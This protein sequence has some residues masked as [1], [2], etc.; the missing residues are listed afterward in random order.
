[1]EIENIHLRDYLRVLRKR[2]MTIFTFF[3]ITITIVTIVTFTMTPSYRAST[4]LLIEKN[5]TNPLDNSSYVRF[6]PEFLETQ[7]QI[8]KG[9]NVARSVV[10]ILSLDIVYLHHF[11]PEDEEKN[12]ITGFAETI[13]ELIAG[14]L[15][16]SELEQELAVNGSEFETSKTP[17][18]MTKADEIALY[19]TE[20]IMVEPVRNSRIVK[21]SFSEKNPVLASMIVNTFAT[22]YMEE[23][24]EINMATSSRAMKWMGKKAEE[25]RIKLEKSER[26]LQ[27]YMKDNDIVTIENKIAI[28]PQ[29]LQEFNLKLT[30]AEA[31]RKE[32]EAEIEKI[33]QFD[34]D[35][36]KIESLPGIADNI[37]LQTLREQI[38]TSEQN[39]EELSKKYGK[40]HPAMIKAMS[41]RDI[42]LEKRKSEIQRLVKSKQ[43]GYELAVT[44]E[45]N[46]RTFLAN[47]K[48]EALLLNERFI[49]H[50]IM[51]RDVE[52]NRLLYQS[53]MAELK[54]QSIANQSQAVNVWVVEPAQIPEFPDKPN[55]K[56]NLLLGLVLGLFG[57]IGLAF[58]IEYLDNTV[59]SVDEIEEKFNVSVLGSIAQFSKKEALVERIAAID[60]RSVISESYRAVRTAILLSSAERPPR[61]I[62]F[63]S[64]SPKEGKTTTT[65]NL[66][67]TIADNDNKVVLIDCDMRKARQHKVHQINNLN[68]LS[69]YLAGLS[70]KDYIYSKP[71]RFS[72][73]IIPAGPAPPNP[74]ELL[75]SQRFKD[76]LDQLDKL[77]DF[78]L[79]DS[80]PILNVTDALLL[81]KVVDATIV[82]CRAGQTNYDFME[83]GLKSL[84]NIDANILGVVVN[85]VDKKNSGYYYY[86]DYKAYYGTEDRN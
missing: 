61:R 44:N 85:G 51:K 11:F 37:A 21:V 15:G 6:D 25:E 77:Y 3:L 32:L 71:D 43:S 42:L 26:A 68:G 70:D 79:L 74:S 39:I 73:D 16:T 5:E 67:T 69:T 12:P 63:S 60:S 72:Y 81:S 27:K 58:F 17:D 23:I 54:K 1:M 35:F 31:D 7:Y 53:L 47:T 33:G 20:E 9:F 40:K 41:D 62:L 64:M 52:N 4:K 59:K 56:I 34:N 8:I 2:R 84:R 13:E 10:K 82:V 66:A 83:K 80:P 19:L 76:L 57:G 78:V 46:L 50:S 36:T 48:R 65:A 38:Q 22:A 55:K 45:E 24:L 86:Y 14:I 28:V 30:K 49:Q 18:A 75:A 29:K